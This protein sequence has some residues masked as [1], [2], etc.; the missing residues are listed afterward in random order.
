MHIGKERDLRDT[1]C[2]NAES[3]R[4]RAGY[5]LAGPGARRV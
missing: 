1:H 3:A 5:V 2:G 4:A